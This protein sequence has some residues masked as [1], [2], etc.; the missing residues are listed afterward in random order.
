MVKVPVTLWSVVLGVMLLGC[1]L[2]PTSQVLYRCAAGACGAGLLCWPDDYCHPLEDGEPPRDAGVDAGEEDAGT[3]AGT[4]DAGLDAGDEDAGFEDAGSDAGEED[5]GFDAGVDAGPCVPLTVCPSSAECGAFDAGCGFSLECGLCS[6]PEECGTLRPN[7]CALPKLCTQGFCWENPLPQGNTLFGVLAFG[8]KAV[9]A[10]GE[11]GTVLFWNGERTFIG[12]VGTNADLR[13]VA[14][15]SNTELFVAGDQGTII[16]YDGLNWVRES[17]PGVYRINVIW[18]APN[19]TAFAGANGGSILKRGAGGVW[20]EMILNPSNTGDIVGLAGLDT[21]VVYATTTTRVYRLPTLV[22]N[23]WLGDTTW[24]A[25][26]RETMTLASV[27]DL[28]FAGGKITGQN[29]GQLFERQPDAG[30]RQYGPNV[31]TGFWGLTL[32]D[33][34]YVGTHGGDVVKIE[35]DGGLSTS[36]LTRDGGLY[37][38]APVAID[39]V[40]AVG[41]FGTMALAGDAGV[42]ELSWGGTAAV[43]ALCGYANSQ[44]YGAANEQIVYERRSSPR[45]VRWDSVTRNSPGVTRWLSC[46]AEG[47]DRTFVMGDDRYYQRQVGGVFMQTDNGI[48]VNWPGV[49]G[50]TTGP[51]YFINSSSQIYSSPTGAVPFTFVAGTS[52]QP[53]AIW[54]VADDDLLIVSQN[55]QVRTHTTGTNWNDVTVPESNR[56]LRAVH[57]QRFADGGVVYSVV[58]NGT[59]WRRNN[60]VFTADA[61]DAGH[62]LRGTWV[63]PQ[64]DI[65]AAGDDGGTTTQGR[66]V[67]WRWVP[68]AGPWQQQPSPAVRPFNTMTGYGDTGP[69]IGG[70]GGAIL[71]KLG[72]DGG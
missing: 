27:G 47:P 14:G 52:S 41:E 44:A 50:S 68:D 66:G 24:P 51:M 8:P 48:N 11:A 16:H 46:F 2:P 71:R 38:V 6:A 35:R 62:A 3:D 17:V 30:W 67:L 58:G 37:A 60:G 54:G 49:W 18:I 59:A 10:V 15:L 65:W 20:A 26:S 4:K 39:T 33:A 69:F 56:F 64:A 7:E 28:L 31:P 12:D 34:P 23:T 70:G 53:H 9:W 32:A 42:R 22:A 29:Y 5:A 36:R 61:I 55:G 21:G 13:A 19:G 63:T 43:N 1:S 72:A 45:G 57:A 40:F 25:P